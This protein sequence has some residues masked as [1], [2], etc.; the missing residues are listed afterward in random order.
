MSTNLVVKWDAEGIHYWP[1]APEEFSVYGQPHEHIFHF[2]VY[3]PV[4]VKS[5]EDRPLELLEVRRSLIG[6]MEDIYGKPF[7][8]GPRSCEGIAIEL[9]RLVAVTYGIKAKTIV[10]EDNFVGAE[11]CTELEHE[12]I[13]S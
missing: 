5:T 11:Y 10:M 13:P 12:L 8:F 9:Y 3:L 2:E 4:N 1:N 7:D 6:K